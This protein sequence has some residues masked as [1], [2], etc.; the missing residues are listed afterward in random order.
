MKR[1]LK[2]R[3]I[4][5]VAVLFLAGLVVLLRE[6]RPS[7]L[8]PG[9]HLRAYVS[10][11]DGTVSVVDIPA[12]S[13][14]AHVSVGPGISGM[15]EH[16]RRAE[17]WGVSSQSG[18]VWVLDAGTN[19]ISARIPVGA[20]PFSLDFSS[21]S[22]TAYTTAWGSDT[23][24]AIDCESR[25]IIASGRTGS[26]PAVATV[27][28][29]G[30]MVLVVN[31]RS[32][33]LGIHD[34]KTLQEIT[35]IPVVSEP[36]DVRVSLDSSVAFVLSRTE[37]QLSVVDL[38]RR[39]LLTNLVLAGKPSEMI[40]KPDGG[41]LYV[42]EPEA[43]GLQAINT[44]THEVGDYVVVGSEP[45]RSVLVAGASELYVSDPVAGSVTPVD[46]YNRKVSRPIAAGQS[47]GALRFDPEENPRLLFVV[48]EGS[49][50][51]AVLRIAAGTPTGLLTMLPV[52]DH[53]QELAVKL[54]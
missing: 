17:I 10:L 32:G 45:T 44:W 1:F 40:L 21:D 19:Q 25:K 48:S 15:R 31:Q 35:E 51:L 8:R 27:T 14:V 13:V 23:V 28:H 9:L 2:F 46:I 16:P 5:V 41:E 18:Y 20:L 47:P 12:L 33:T 34:P 49:G 29:D 42:I 4:F 38:K 37:A 43:H 53:P 30:K 3:I 50:D 7:F 22:H 26:G 52:G 6:R 54:Y 39:V 36:E 11:A 24:S